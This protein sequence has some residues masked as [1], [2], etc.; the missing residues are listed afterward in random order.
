MKLHCKLSGILGDKRI[1][2]SDLIKATKI[3]RNTVE[4]LY[5]DTARNINFNIVEKI[6]EYLECDLNELFYFKNDD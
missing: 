4:K 3:S 5:Y 1:K 2:R 6:C